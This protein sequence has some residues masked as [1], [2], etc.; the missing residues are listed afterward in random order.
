MYLR[1]EQ[2]ARITQNPLE[3]NTQRELH[4]IC[5]SRLDLDPADFGIVSP[6]ADNDNFAVFVGKLREWREIRYM[7]VVPSLTLGLVWL[8]LVVAN[9]ADLAV[10][11]QD[12]GKMCGICCVRGQ[13]LSLSG[14]GKTPLP[15]QIA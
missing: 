2:I 8:F 6:P 12:L 15:V 3:Y 4:G 9:R 11:T 7:R 13:F 14:P 5:I 10:L 1:R